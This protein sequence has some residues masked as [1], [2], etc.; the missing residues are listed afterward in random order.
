M[1]INTLRL[2]ISA[3]LLLAASLCASRAS[4]AIGLDIYFVDTEGGAATLIVSSSGESTLIDCGNP[5]ERDAERIFRAAKQAGLK[6]ID[7]LIITHWHLDHYGGAEALARKLPI[8]HCFDRGIPEVSTDDP[9][10]FPKLI[11]AYKAVS[12]GTSKKLNPGDEV[13]LKQTGPSPLHLRCLVARG[14]TV[15]DQPDAPKNGFARAN[16][17]MP[18]DT[19]DNARSLGF[20]LMY[21]SFRF[22]D[23]GDL[24]W[25][26]EYKLVAPTDKIGLID[27]Y[28]STHHGLDISNN[29]VL[30]RTVRPLVAIY[31][32][33][34]HK[35]GAPALTTT[36]RDIGSLQAIFQLH[37]NL[38]AKPE[39]NA[40]A[41]LIANSGSE[42]TCKGEYIKLSVAPDSNS[43]TVQIGA[44]GKPV[45]FATRFASK[46]P[47]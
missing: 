20:I 42:P 10:N 31:N 26:I 33:G 17:P 11:A 38:D 35:G 4:A 5:G 45:R 29:P 16:K 19:S 40:P 18:E 37:R 47:N 14:E 7:N 22:L 30:V 9:T 3:L 23:L 1:R 32:N 28:Q 12:Q 25:N 15:P 21:G 44:K 34:P 41:D 2:F 39:E 46:S 6:Q 24:T 27:V 36:L 43:Y 13:P 8:K